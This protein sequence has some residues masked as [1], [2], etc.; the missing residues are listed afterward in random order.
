MVELSKKEDLKRI[1]REIQGLERALE[2]KP[3]KGAVFSE[4]IKCG[5]PGCKCMRGSGHGPY[6]YLSYWSSSL[7]R[8]VRKYLGKR[9]LQYYNLARE[10]ILQRLQ[11][12]RRKEADILGQAEGV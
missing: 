9:G 3:L 10:E 1:R 5:K 12:L 11:D 2:F 4:R 6:W 7:G 8:P